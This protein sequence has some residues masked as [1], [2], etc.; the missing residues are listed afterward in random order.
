MGATLPLDRTHKE[1]ARLSEAHA[2]L[3]DDVALSTDFLEKVRVRVADGPRARQMVVTVLAD[4]WFEPEAQAPSGALVDLAGDFGIGQAGARTVLAR[5]ARDQRVV[6]T[7]EGR[8][9]L[10][11]FTSEFHRRVEMGVDRMHSFGRETR[12]SK[13]WTC[14]AFSI[15][16]QQRAIRYK[17]RKG[18]EWLGFAPLYD[19]FW[20]SPREVP[21]EAERLIS[22]LEIASASVFVADEVSAGTGYGWPTDA[23]DLTE[24]R[25]TY[26]LF[27]EQA[28]AVRDL[29]RHGRFDERQ[30]LVWRTQLVNVWR[31]VP[32]LDPDLPPDLLPPDWPRERARDLFEELYRDLA[33]PAEHRVR[34]AV[35]RQAPHYVDQV[36]AHG[37]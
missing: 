15:P 3:A 30:A 35:R 32:N 20:V 4:Y 26:D 36:R 14:V 7:K 1:L 22:R 18:L 25:A 29:V 31:V 33:G 28:E 21:T 34:A 19:G 17:L 11:A 10:Y 37:L 5:L 9:T 16:E 2:A 23:W 13:R 12:T 27:L 6:V 24:I 8:R